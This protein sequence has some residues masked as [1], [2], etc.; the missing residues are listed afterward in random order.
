MKH[1][2][3]RR[4]YKTNWEIARDERELHAKL[5]G[6]MA[7]I[8]MPAKPWY[9]RLWRKVRPLRGI[10]L[11]PLKSGT[12]NLITLL[13]VALFAL[14]AHAADPP[15]AATYRVLND[16]LLVF[17]TDNQ[18]QLSPD[19]GDSR[20]EIRDAA[21]NVLGRVSDAGTTGVIGFVQ[22]DVINGSFASQ[23]TSGATANRAVTLPDAAGEIS[24]L[25]QTIA[26][27]EIVDGT[28]VNADVSAS[29]AIVPTKFSAG[30]N[31]QAVV[32]AG[33]VSGWGTVP[34]AGIT[35]DTIVNADINSAAA[36]AI[37]KLS[38]VG[39]SADYVLTYNGSAIVWAANAGGSIEG[40]GP[41]VDGAIPRMDGTGGDTLQGYSSNTITASDAG[42]LTV[43]G[44]MLVG[45]DMEIE[46]ASILLSDSADLYFAR[47]DEI[48]W[49][50][51]YTTGTE[52]GIS[53]ET[54]LAFDAYDN[55]GNF[56]RRALQLNRTASEGVVIG[57][58]A[59]PTPLYVKGDIYAHTS[60]AQIVDDGKVLLAALAQ[61][62]ATTGQVL[63]W[64]G[65]TYAPASSAVDWANPGEIGT[66]T[67]N[68]G[69]F[70]TLFASSL[71]LSTP[72][73]DAN[74]AD[75]LTIGASSTVA[76]AALSANV[77][78]VNAVETIA[79]DWVNTANPWAD[80]E[81][82]N[83]LTSSIFVGSGSSTDAIDLA[84]AEVAGVLADANVASDITIASTSALSAVGITTTGALAVNHSSGIT[85]DQTTFPLVNATATTVN[86]GGA[87]TTMNIAKD[88]QGA[89]TNFQ[90]SAFNFGSLGT[91][92][93]DMVMTAT[94][95][96]NNTTSPTI[97]YR[98]AR[99]SGGL[100]QVQANDYLGAFEFR[101][102]NNSAAYSGV[103]AMFRV[104]ALDSFTASA[105]GTQFIFE[106]TPI[107]S[108]SRAANLTVASAG[109]TL[110]SPLSLNG[111][112]TIGDAAGD[113]LHVNANTITFEG[114]T[115]DANEL[116]FAIPTLTGDR[117]VTFRDTDGTIAYLADITGGA[118]TA[119]ILWTDA[120]EV[121][122]VGAGEDDG[123][124]YTVPAAT[125]AANKDH[126]DFVGWYFLKDD[127]TTAV[128]VKY[129]ATTVFTK[130]FTPTSGD[131]Y[132][133]V[134][135][136]IVRTGAATQIAIFQYTGSGAI[137]IGGGVEQY[138]TPTETLSGTV[139]F[140]STVESTDTPSNNDVTQK[141]GV[142]KKGTTP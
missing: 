117:T 19:S 16:K 34:S 23:I 55:D 72:L 91:S 66:V 116:A 111:N 30:T 24:L 53:G 83:T 76:D 9:V 14:G 114:G 93:V 126:L 100:Q 25:G 108:T 142:I 50:V 36:I 39:A 102:Y 56:L 124:S 40:A 70:T 110:V 90:G 41:L 138:T 81:V 125:L 128:R 71:T 120:T 3:F 80:N 15:A 29:A 48:R 140:K 130:T 106:T 62:S 86:F 115:A 99:Y 137:S 135:G 58:V 18:F 2:R 61:T 131:G 74:V 123:M 133:K 37:T 46:A 77:A 89:A 104:Q 17:G 51:L 132:A 122:N 96:I 42:L 75:T 28:I 78:H 73:T 68:I 20:L 82:S 88:A 118:G 107:G 141:W 31:G 8:I 54:S 63:Q 13:A 27:G 119:V 97:N 60:D 127:E 45:D 112:T 21:G 101:G 109:S 139:V 134:T 11:R 26:T 5:D 92:G 32:T 38:S 94:N 103:A 44:G 69:S 6:D 85:T 84:T 10:E 95:T 67:P 35:D 64:N 33:G 59:A 121:G 79:S 12:P 105:T 87:A 4:L 136:S 52:T 49:D 129:G 7:E 57:T 65:T 1:I 98:K 43:P 113:A 47:D 22:H